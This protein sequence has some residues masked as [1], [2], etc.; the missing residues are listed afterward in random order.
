MSSLLS[1]E[2]EDALEKKMRRFDPVYSQKFN[3]HAAQQIVNT[4]Q[5]KLNRTTVEWKRKRLLKQ[6][7]I[8]VKKLEEEEQA[9]E[10]LVKQTK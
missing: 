4:I 9:L 1:E 3:V 7:D 8:A 2:E 6:W 5:E 10:L